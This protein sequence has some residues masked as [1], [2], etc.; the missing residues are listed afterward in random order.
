MRRARRVMPARH[1]DDV[2]RALRI[3]RGRSRPAAIGL[4]GALLA[5]AVTCVPTDT[6][7]ARADPPPSSTCLATAQLA[8][9][10]TGTQVACLQFLLG[11]GGYYT[12][13]LTSQYDRATAQAVAAYQS[14][15]PPLE[16]NGVAAVP[17]LTEMGI[18]E[19]ADVVAAA[20]D[21][22]TADANLPAGSTGPPVECIQRHLSD[23]GLF[24]DLV[25]GVLGPATV[26]ALKVFQSKNPPLTVDG[27]PGP[28]TLAAL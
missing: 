2:L 6:R 1:N 26:A 21:T 19:S 16:A 20:T 25:D 14:A 23:V 15:H 24:P 13:E 8:P 10:A 5:V 9:G 4:L 12:G 27:L 28:R 18:Y 3:G 17:T 22:C 11:L 7:V